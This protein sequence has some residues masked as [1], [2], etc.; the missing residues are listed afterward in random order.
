MGLRGRKGK[1][2]ESWYFI[3]KDGRRI[4][5]DFKLYKYSG[6]KYPITAKQLENELGEGNVFTKS[7]KEYMEK[8]NE[9]LFG[10]SDI[11]NY[12]DLLN[13]LIQIRS[14]KL[15]KDFKPTVIYDILKQSLNT[16]SDDD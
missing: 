2:L 12:K 15:S 5:H 10:Y 3:L 14:P 11:E 4:N 6:E 13:L 7:Q 16:L 1:P 9:N 8:V